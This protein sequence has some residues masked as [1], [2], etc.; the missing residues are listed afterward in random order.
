MIEQ[1]DD[2]QPDSFWY[3]APNKGAPIAF[4]ILFAVSGLWHLYLCFKLRC[5]KVTGLLPWSAILF[6]AGFIFRAIGAFGNWDKLNVYIV[7]QCLL[8]VG[9][10]IYEAANFLTLGR[11]LYYIPYH[12]P[13]HPGRVFTTFVAL[14]LMIESLTASGASLV[15]NTSNPESVQ[16]AGKSLMK[17]SLI[18]QLIQMAGFVSIV[19][20]FYRR[21]SRDGLLADKIKTPLHVLLASC[22]LISIRTVYRTVEYFDAASLTVWNVDQMSSILKNEWYFWVFEAMIMYANTTML[23]LLHPMTKLPESN[24]IYLAKDGV[25]EVEGP[26]FQEQRPLLMTFI[27]PFDVVGLVMR[28][29]RHEKFWEEGGSARVKTGEV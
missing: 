13:I 20:L 17:A 15:S 2:Y 9:P 6:T 18:L 10:P 11:I 28:K 22:I 1:R 25:T 8:L 27:D 23:N 26:G 12:A 24:K 4:A 19:L 5:W 3:Y 16:N 14:G 7:S 21:C 29:N